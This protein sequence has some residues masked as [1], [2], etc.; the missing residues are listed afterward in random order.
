MDSVPCHTCKTVTHIQIIGSPVVSF[1]FKGLPSVNT[2]YNKHFR[3]RGID[4][5]EWRYEAKEKALAFIKKQKRAIPVINRG[6]V[7]VKVWPPHEGIMDIH[8]VL[9][10]PLFDGF[11]AAGLWIDD[12]W[13]FLP[14]VM[15][16]WAGV[17]NYKPREY[18][19]RRTVLD[20]HELA[21]ICENDEFLS[22][23][24]GR[25]WMIDTDWD[26]YMN[27]ISKI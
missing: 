17:G 2:H 20:I 21:S 7:V 1:E 4:T 14:L 26:N 18:K 22:L 15:T 16:L 19:E 25:K 11:T 9:L 10:K 13:V 27:E 12:E 8:N 6:L 24:K 23:P 5:A 3:A